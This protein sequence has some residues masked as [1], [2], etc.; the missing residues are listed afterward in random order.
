M[1]GYTCT[2][3]LVDQQFNGLQLCLAIT[4]LYSSFLSI[5]LNTVGRKLWPTFHFAE[6]QI[7]TGHGFGITDLM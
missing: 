6:C 5:F 2:L 1:H 3:V 4:L 7:Q